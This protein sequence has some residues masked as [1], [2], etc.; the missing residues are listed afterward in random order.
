MRCPQCQQDEHVVKNGKYVRKSDK[1]RIQSFLCKA[2]KK[3][4]STQTFQIDYRHRKRHINQQAFRLLC[5][6]V[7]QRSCA[8]LLGVRPKA[9]AIRIKRF[10]EICKQNLE[11]Y[12]NTR[13]KVTHAQLDE[14][15]TFEKCKYR[16]LTVPVVVEA[17][18][19][20][21][22]SLAV[23]SIA[24][25][26][27]LAKK[28]RLKDGYRKCERHHCLKKVLSDLK[29]AADKGILISSDDSTHYPKVIKNQLPKAKHRRYLS[30]RSRLAGLGELK[31]G[32][33]DPIFSINHT[34]AKMRDCIKRLS[35]RTWATTKKAS[36]LENLLF[37]Y[38]WFHN[39]RL[40]GTK[41]IFL[42]RI[43]VTN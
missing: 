41:G 32:G 5:Q 24:A 29:Q 8:F 14:L 28:G 6:G 33:F 4:F 35:R 43:A 42:K 31:K 36:E 40:D 20:K 1:K 23:G 9:I 2:C 27:H 19:R 37:M 26:G 12:R 16:P 39:L 22:I 34:L 13:S 17:K 25:K 18:S 7:S 3:R 21:I 38:A 15:E 11:G 10:G 30:Q